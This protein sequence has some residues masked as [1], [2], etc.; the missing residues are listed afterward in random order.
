MKYLVNII[1][2]KIVTGCSTQENRATGRTTGQALRLI[3]TAMGQ[4]GKS[5]GI[6]DHHDASSGRLDGNATNSLVYR[7]MELISA[8]KLLGFTV[9]RDSLGKHVIIYNP[10]VPV[11][12]VVEEW[13][14][15]KREK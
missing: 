3:G 11:E 10:L 12:Q 14:D 6:L 7:M 13:H 5:I 9:A 2:G 4:P 1:T 15:G 8:A